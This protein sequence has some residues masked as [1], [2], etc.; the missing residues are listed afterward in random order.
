MAM[1][2]S[3][4]GN[5]AQVASIV[6]GFGATALVFRLQRHLDQLPNEPGEHS[7]LPLAD[8]LLIAAMIVAVAA[9]VIPL[10][11]FNLS[12][13]KIPRAACAASCVLLAGYVFAVLAHYRLIFGS[14]IR[15]QTYPLEYSVAKAELVITIVALVLAIAAACSAYVQDSC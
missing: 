11:A 10:L 15:Y 1:C 2:I 4:A 7:W 9:A 14:G 6:A 12:S 8:W 13:T 3:D 5:I